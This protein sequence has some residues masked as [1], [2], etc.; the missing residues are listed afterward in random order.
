MTTAHSDNSTSNRR[1][2]MWDRTVIIIM[3]LINVASG[4]QGTLHSFKNFRG[5]L[6]LMYILLISYL[7]WA[8]GTPTSCIQCMLHVSLSWSCTVKTVLPL[9][10]VVFLH[11]YVHVYVCTF[12]VGIFVSPLDACLPFVPM[13]TLT[14]STSLW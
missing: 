3:L 14:L 12:C 6:S 7:P 8:C 13:Q 11:M 9:E 5:H 10:F 4:K 1:A 2:E